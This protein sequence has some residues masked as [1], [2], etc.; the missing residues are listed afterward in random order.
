MKQTKGG[1]AGGRIWAGVALLPLAL[2]GCA[3]MGAGGPRT[4]AVTAADGRAITLNDGAQAGVNIRVVPVDAAVVRASS[5]QVAAQGLGRVLGDG[6]VAGSVIGRGDVVDISVWEAPPAVLFGSGGEWRAAAYGTGT[7]AGGAGG[8]ATATRA[9]LPEQM[10]DAGGMITV[11][12]VGPVVAA[13]RTPQ[14]IAADITRRLGGK[15][16]DPQVMLRVVRNATANVTVVGEVASSARIGLTAR[17]E[18]LLDVLAAA[19]GVRQPVGKVTVQVSRAGRVAA[20]PLEAVIRDPAQNIRMQADDVVTALY[21]PY[22]F[23]ALGATGT[24]AEVAFE[25]TGLTLAQA[26]GRIGGLR[27]DRANPRG[28][29]I[30][31]IERDPALLAAIGVADGAPGGVPVIYRLDMSDPASLFWAQGFAVQH[32]D[33]IYV[34]NAPA[35]DLQKFVGLVSQVAVTGLT[36]GSVAP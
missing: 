33:V 16:H 28:L 22:S 17:G 10:V 31:R 11:P 6:V 35:A 13:G 34:S 24:N 18:R 9:S 32:R 23:T 4:G 1:R 5:A 21:Q 19:G 12:F 2:A 14:Q 30:F 3:Q 27:D 8:L 15:A 29:F 26:L 25:G 20:M 7:L 36:I